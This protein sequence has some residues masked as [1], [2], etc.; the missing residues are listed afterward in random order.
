MN[1]SIEIGA[2]GTAELIVSPEDTA[3]ALGSGDVPVLGTPRL[4][5]LLEEA[6]CEALRGALPTDRTTV[7]SAVELSHRRPTPVGARV[8]AHARVASRDGAQ[9][10]FDV[11]ADHETAAGERVEMIARGRITRVVVDR[12]SFLG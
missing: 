12:G 6:T 3:I 8:I 1:D 10:V 4:L 5:A 2:E 9:V 7:G 11:H